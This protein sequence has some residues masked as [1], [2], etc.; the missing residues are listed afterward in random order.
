[1]SDSVTAEIV[2]YTPSEDYLD[3]PLTLLRV[4]GDEVYVDSGGTTTP[5]WMG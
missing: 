5:G 4:M 3:S 2:W 1:M